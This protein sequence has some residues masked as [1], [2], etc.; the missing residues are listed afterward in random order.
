M[1]IKTTA[2]I[3]SGATSNFIDIEF[4]KKYHIPQIAKS[5]PTRIETIDGRPLCS[6]LVKYETIPITMDLDTHTE[7]IRFDAITIG[8]YQIILGIPWLKIHN[9]HILWSKDQIQFPNCTHMCSMTSV[10]AT[11]TFD[12]IPEFEPEIPSN[13]DSI[14]PEEYHAY[15]EVFS[16]EKSNTLP[17]HSSYDHFIPLLENTTPPYGPIYSLSETELS[18]LSTYLED[19]LK[20]GF[21]RPSSSPAGA[22]ILFVK[23]KDGTLRLCVDYRGLNKITVKNRYP[24]PLIHEMLDRL[25]GSSIY[26]KLD[27]RGAYNLVRIKEGEEWKTAF[28]TRYGHFEYTVMPFGLTNAPATFQA[29]INDALRPYLDVFIIVYLDDILIFSKSPEEHKNHVCKVLDILL[30]HGLYVNSD[31]SCFNQQHID[32]LGYRIS[33]QGIS[34]DPSKLSSISEWPQPTSLKDIQSFLGFANFYRR[35]IDNYAKIAQPLTNL[36]RKDVPFIVDEKVIHSFNHLKSCFMGPKILQHFDPQLDIIL[37]TDASDFAIGGVLSQVNSDGTTHPIAYYSR[38]LSPAEQNYPISDK[39]ML[40]IVASV[41]EWRKYLEGSH[42]PFL[43]L[44]DHKNLEYFMTMK[45]LNRRQARW[46][47]MLSGFTYKIKY[48]PG[49]KNAKADALSRRRDY[50]KISEE[51]KHHND[52]V[53]IPPDKISICAVVHS[54]NKG[55]QENNLCEKS[56]TQTNHSIIDL[57]RDNLLKDS[58]YLQI[59]SYLDNPNASHTK[60]VGYNI[61]NNVLYFHNRVYVPDIDCIRLKIIQEFHD[62]QNAGHFGSRKTFNLVHRYYHWPKIKQYIQSYVKTCDTC[63]RNKSPRH[64]PHGFL[65]PLEIPRRP[66]SSIGMDFIVKLPNSQGYD[67]ILCV[68]DRFTKMAHFIPCLE[69]IDSVNLANLFVIHIFKHH[70]LPESIISD[71]GPLFL[72]NFWQSLLRQLKVNSQLSSAYHPQTDGQAERTNAILEQYLRMYCNY[73]QDDWVQFLPFAEFSYNNALQDSINKT[74]FE[75][76][77]GFHPVFSPDYQDSSLFPMTANYMQKLEEIQ[78]NLAASIRK[79]QLSQS[80]YYDK[81]K[82]QISFNINDK[83]WLLRKFIKTQRPCDKLDYKRLGPFEISEKIND[84]AY[85]LRLPINMKMHNVFH[86]S[87]LEKYHFDPNPLRIQPPPPPVI[88]DGYEEFEVSAILDSRVR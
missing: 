38:K 80:H 42:S 41:M 63:H 25:T 47:E 71:R 67:S 62:S 34:M 84:V 32:F 79:A 30:R 9:P 11:M 12:N 83:V 60:N 31:K 68:V 27:L 52:R 73:S 76:N 16:I 15:L 75:A 1:H 2:L 20:K 7:T 82:L 13:V 33:S 18:A 85:R 43:I 37:E 72:S 56:D 44:T 14:V 88:I 6:G 45:S 35:F 58:L 28:R 17:N 23:K 8:H 86:V 54:K 65:K 61:K 48:S 53:L 21:I 57:I 64:K 19:N 5:T 50:Q 59:K 4:C 69:T 10:N 3:D 87:L 36:L 24:L 55:L 81:K 40:A 66:W 77:Y 39:E 22:P 29:L 49:K 46:A 70:G 74:P 78:D 51:E 26:T